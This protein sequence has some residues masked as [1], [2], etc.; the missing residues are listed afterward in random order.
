M[1]PR[2]ATSGWPISLAIFGGSQGQDLKSVVGLTVW[3]PQHSGHAPI[4]LLALEVSFA[5][6]RE[7][8]CLGG[9]TTIMAVKKIFF[10]I[11]RPGGEYIAETSSRWE[12][13]LDWYR[14]FKVCFHPYHAPIPRSP[15]NVD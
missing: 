12:E 4:R 2:I 14:G 15:F 1:G 11:D 7:A 10:P 13:D 6:G 9:N 8:V 3:L 5:D